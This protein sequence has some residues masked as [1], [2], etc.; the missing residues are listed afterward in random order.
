MPV[1]RGGAIYCYD[2]IMYTH[3]KYHISHVKIILKGNSECSIDKD[4][5]FS[6]YFPKNWQFARLLSR[7]SSYY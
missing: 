4:K 1:A 2:I 6:L 5:F 7:E 3:Y